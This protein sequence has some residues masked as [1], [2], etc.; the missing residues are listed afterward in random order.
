[1]S[2]Q[3]RGVETFTVGFRDEDIQRAESARRIARAFGTNT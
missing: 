1:M 2:E 3:C